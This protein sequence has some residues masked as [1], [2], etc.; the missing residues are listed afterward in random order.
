M[1]MAE[2]KTSSIDPYARILIN[3]YE[4][5]PDKRADLASALSEMG[6]AK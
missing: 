2:R 1:T 6:G 4:V 3:V 5:E